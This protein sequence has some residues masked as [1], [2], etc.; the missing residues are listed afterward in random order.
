MKFATREGFN[1]YLL[2]GLNLPTTKSKTIVSS[3]LEAEAAP[4]KPKCQL[5]H[6]GKGVYRDESDPP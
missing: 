2:A 3:I 5:P 1:A 6:A 4:A